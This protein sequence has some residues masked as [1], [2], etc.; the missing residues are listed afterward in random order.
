L[1]NTHNVSVDEVY[2]LYNKTT[3]KILGVF[4]LTFKSDISTNQYSH[5]DQLE[6]E[7]TVFLDCI[8]RS[9]FSINNDRVSFLASYRNLP[10]SGFEPRA[11]ISTHKTYETGG[12]ELY[13]ERIR[14]QRVGSLVMSKIITWL[15]TYPLNTDVTGIHFAPSGNPEG[16]KRFYQ[17]IGMPINGDMTT[18]GNLKLSS[19][20]K[21]NIQTTSTLG[22]QC[23]IDELSAK[24]KQAKHQ[25][26]IFKPL[27][28][29][30]SDIEF[31]YNL[32]TAFKSYHF[33]PKILPDI[34]CNNFHYATG[35]ES[36][37]KEVATSYLEKTI[38]LEEL[39]EKIQRDLSRISEF[40]K[41]KSH[42]YRWKNLA[43]AAKSLAF[44]HRE[45][46]FKVFLFL[47][48]ILILYNWIS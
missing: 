29:K 11:S 45:F 24:I 2:K 20:W 23:E 4:A 43:S 46:L 21:K 12:I 22:L 19:S 16:V 42:E 34:E 40:N 7:F 36:D 28:Q 33:E 17:N 14:G 9:D 44:I 39:Q 47:L 13:P 5:K 1:N 18:I 10:I 37:V 31:S 32:Y 8:W 26:E 35:A 48:I 25:L 41:N 3:G 27:K 6:A 30:M 38:E 15:K